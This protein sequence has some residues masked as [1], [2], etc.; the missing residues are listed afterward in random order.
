MSSHYFLKPG[1]PIIIVL[2]AHQ[3]YKIPKGTRSAG[4]LYI[5][6]Q[7]VGKIRSFR[8]SRYMLETARERGL[9]MEG[10]HRYGIHSCH[11]QRHRVAV[12]GHVRYQTPL[13]G[14]YLENAAYV[15]Y[16]ANY[17]DGLS[18]VRTEV[19]FKVVCG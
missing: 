10:S 8:P 19:I 2:L 9:P 16:E 6:L 4:M 3:R 18:R 11:F 5:G 1:I 17:N 13:Q 15:A 14:Q 12:K 7:G